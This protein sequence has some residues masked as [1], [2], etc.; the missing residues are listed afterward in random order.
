VLELCKWATDV[1]L[2]LSSSSCVMDEMGE[3]YSKH[4]ENGKCNHFGEK[5][6]QEE[7][8]GQTDVVSAF[9]VYFCTPYKECISKIIFIRQELH[10]S[11]F[12]RL[13]VSSI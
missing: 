5:V 2:T 1:T 10:V 4:R 7:T 3:T 9:C 11:T 12:Y 13:S 6:S 8:Q